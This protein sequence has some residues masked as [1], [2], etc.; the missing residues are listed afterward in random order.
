MANQTD[1]RWP[2]SPYSE[3]EKMFIMRDLHESIREAHDQGDAERIRNL[4]QIRI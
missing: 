4:R 2:T 1:E 3:A